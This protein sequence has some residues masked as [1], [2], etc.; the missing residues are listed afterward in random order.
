MN[1]CINKIKIIKISFIPTFL[2]KMDLNNYY[3]LYLFLP[4]NKF[5]YLNY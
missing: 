5:P 2:K 1:K 3:S 4:F